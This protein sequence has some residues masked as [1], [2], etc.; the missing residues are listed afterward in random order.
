MQLYGLIFNFTHY[1]N[2]FFESMMRNIEKL[3]FIGLRWHGIIYL[4]SIEV[5]CSDHPSFNIWDLLNENKF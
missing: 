2:I 4:R 1:W 3:E 5:I